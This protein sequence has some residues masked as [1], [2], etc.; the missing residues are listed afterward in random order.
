MLTCRS[1][2]KKRKDCE[3]LKDL[4]IS[5]GSQAYW[6]QTEVNFVVWVYCVYTYNDNKV[7]L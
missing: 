2:C 6:T 4:K 5:Q 3:K 7:K 1:L